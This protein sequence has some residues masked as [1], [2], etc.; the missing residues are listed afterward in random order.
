MVGATLVAPSAGELIHEIVLAMER[1]LKPTHLSTAIHVYPTL[2]LGL[3]RAA[4]NYTLKHLVR[5]W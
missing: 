1:G 4:D 5:E 2:A 3:R